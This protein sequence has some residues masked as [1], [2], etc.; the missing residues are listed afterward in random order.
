MVAETLY[1]INRLFFKRFRGFFVV[2]VTAAAHC[3]ILPDEYAFSVAEIVKAVGGVDVS[4]PAAHHIAPYIV[5]QPERFAEPLLVSAMERVERDPVST[6]NKDFSAVYVKAEFAVRLR[7]PRLEPYRA[8]AE[9]EL[10]RIAQRAFMIQFYH[11]SVKIRL[12]RRARRPQ[13]RV[14]YEHPQKRVGMPELILR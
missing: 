6:H 5:K 2:R 8:D 1:L 12:S 3:E 14:V 9:I 10:I 13:I 11:R 4:A 7:F